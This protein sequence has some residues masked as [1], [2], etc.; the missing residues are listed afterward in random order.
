MT[1]P[2]PEYLRALA[3]RRLAAQNDWAS[4]RGWVEDAEAALRAAANQL[5]AVQRMH[6][7]R[8]WRPLDG[9]FIGGTYCDH[10][11]RPWPCNTYRAATADTAPQEGRDA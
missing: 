5:E 4:S 11:R 8:E 7:E 10:C 1:A 3:D 6:H 2:T 9:T